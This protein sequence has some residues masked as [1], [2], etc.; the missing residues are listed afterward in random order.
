MINFI[1]TYSLFL[2][3]FIPAFFNSFIST[4]SLIIFFINPCLFPYSSIPIIFSLRLIFFSFFHSYFFSHFFNQFILSFWLIPLF[5]HSDSLFLFFFFSFLSKFIFHS[6]VFHFSFIFILSC[7]HGHF[8]GLHSYLFSLFS[9]RLIFFFFSFL[10]KLLPYHSE[11][12]FH[13][14][15]STYYLFFHS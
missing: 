12:F 8:F 6:D 2:H 13:S 14:F 11:L 7:F 5:F 15:I 10:I 4:H 3:S 1:P 9:L